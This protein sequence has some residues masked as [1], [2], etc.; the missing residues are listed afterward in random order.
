[1]KQAGITGPSASLSWKDNEV[2]GANFAFFAPAGATR[3]E[4]CLFKES[5]EGSHETDHIDLQRDKNEVTGPDGQK[6]H[7]WQGFVPDIKEGQRYGFRRHGPRELG[8]NPNK[9]L[10]EPHPEEKTEVINAW[11]ERHKPDNNKNNGDI[12]A[13]SRVVNWQALPPGHTKWLGATPDKKRKGTN[14]AFYTAKEGV[15]GVELCLFDPK[16]PGHETSRVELNAKEEVKG[17]DGQ[18]IGYIWNGFAEGV[19]EGQL[20]GFRVHGE[21]NPEKE[22]YFNPYKV[23]IDPCAKAVTGE[24]HEWDQRHLHHDKYRKIHNRPDMSRHDNAEVIPKARVVDWQHLQARVTKDVPVGAI[25]PH[26]DTVLGEMHVERDTKFFPGIPEGHGGTY[27]ALANN[28]WIKW[29]KDLS[30][31]SLELMPIESYGTDAPLADRHKINGFGY[32]TNVPQAPHTEYAFDKKRPEE[33]LA[34]TIRALKQN[35]IET[36]M[37]VVPNHTLESG[38]YGPLLNLRGMDSHL[39]MPNG[40]D[41]TGVGNTRDFG[42]PINRRMFLEELEYWRGLGVAGFRID[43]APVI[44][45]EGYKNFNSDSPMMKALRQDIGHENGLKDVK[46]YGE[47]WHTKGQFIGAFA[48]FHPQDAVGLL[49]PKFNSQYNPRGNPLAEWNPASRKALQDSLRPDTHPTRGQLVEMMGGSHSNYRHHGPQGGVNYIVSHDGFTFDDFV[50]YCEKHNEANGED[51]RDGG[52]ERGHN[53]GHEGKTDNPDIIANRR[54]VQRFATT[55]LALSQGT[56]MVR[57]ADI[58]GHSQGG[59]NNAYCKIDEITDTKWRDNVQGDERT[60]FFKSVLQFRKN[61]SSLR[62]ATYLQGEPD[63]A[64]DYKF[65]GSDMKDVTW[66][67]EHGHEIPKGDS[68]WNQSGGFSMLLSGDPGNS[69]SDAGFTRRVQRDKRDIPLLVLVNPTKEDMNFKLPVIPGITWR[70]SINSLNPK[71]I[72]TGVTTEE[73]VSGKTINV[74]WRSTITFEGQR[75]LEKGT[76]SAAVGAAR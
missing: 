52:H 38:T 64:S 41:Y 42:H 10:V 69:S 3:V 50:A 1:M 70:S 56:P 13:K 31:T 46:F 71:D 12:A 27:K 40:V 54:R 17:D 33:E 76:K 63:K 61:H 44:G 32:M 6:G 57:I 21:Y 29:V 73:I 39:Y 55:M 18:L 75:K 30:V 65:N 9:L 8:F 34:E 53:W 5:K 68:Q 19:N 60:E 43:L 47:P 48:G 22:Q 11:D 59:N 35:G 72:N 15:E 62:R 2:R 16:D 25:Y 67:N 66:L 28:K 7:M 51:N 58:V 4:L 45:C 14:F 23:L 49:A 20:Y 26:A 24:I 37:D 36:I 74:G